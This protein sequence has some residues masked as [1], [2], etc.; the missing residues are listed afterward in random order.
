MQERTQG[1]LRW[2]QADVTPNLGAK[3]DKNSGFSSK[4]VTNSTGWLEKVLARP[5][6]QG[7]ALPFLP[8]GQPW[9]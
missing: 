4:S 6:L 9:V 7:G 2:Y 3:F 8:K 5:V 1:V